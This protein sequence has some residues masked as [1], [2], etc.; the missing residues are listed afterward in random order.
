MNQDDKI[1]D[2]EMFGECST[3]WKD[4][5]AAENIWAYDQRSNRKANI[6]QLWG[7]VPAAAV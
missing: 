5:C 2:S 3:H 7:S 1:K 6:S 4:D